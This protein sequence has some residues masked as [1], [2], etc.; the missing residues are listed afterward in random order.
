MYLSSLRIAIAG[1]AFCVSIL[2]AVASAEIDVPRERAARMVAEA[3]LA[4]PESGHL[5]FALSS[6]WLN[7]R[8]DEGNDRL[9]QWFQTG[10]RSEQPLETLLERA[11]EYPDELAR[12]LGGVKWSARTWLRIYYLF[13][14]R[15]LFFPGRLASDVEEKL[16]AL[17]W[18][19]GRDQSTLE[20]AD[21][22]YIWAIQGSENHDMM[23]LSNAFLAL[24]AVRDH[25]RYR[26]RELRDGGT[27]REHAAAWVDYYR[28]YARERA[29]YGLFV[30]ISSPIYGKHFLGELFNMH[31]F[32][33]DPVLRRSI[34]M[35]L[36]VTWADWAVDQLGGVRGGGK[37]RAYFG[38]YAER[39]TSDSW[40]TMSNFL[41]E[42]PTE[43]QL[44]W[45][46]RHGQVEFSIATSSYRLPEVVA[47]IALDEKGRGEFEYI[48]RRPAR[49][50][51]PEEMRDR[52][53]LREGTWYHLD[54]MDSRLVRYSYCTPAYVLGSLWLDPSLGTEFR[55]APDL[56]FS[57]D[58]NYAAISS[59]SQWQG[60][61]FPTDPNARV[62]PQCEGGESQERVNYA[63]HVA[64]QHK[65][66]L[67]V[68]K[69]RRAKSAGAMRV[70]FAPGMKER[71]VEREGW[72]YLEEGDAFLAVGIASHDVGAAASVFHWKGDRWLYLDDEFSP[73][74]FVAG[75]TGS[76]GDLEAFIASVQE[77]RYGFS[78]NEFSYSFTGPEGEGTRLS[79]F[80]GKVQGVPWINGAPIDFAPAKV[81]DSPFLAADFGSP[82]V[83]IRK[84]DRELV[85]DF[86]AVD[87]AVGGDDL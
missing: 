85:H 27:A 77:H 34:G 49:M 48:S 70:Y 25:P 71:L 3:T 35:L 83:T 63:Q 17:C 64:V 56:D 54:P 26:E 72:L 37:T 51:R 65:N 44:Q 20:R 55:L 57:A 73:V 42:R 10:H 59:Q 6:L 28:L 45:A 78:G 43:G 15:S 9:R 38:H 74:I 32:G 12:A 40:Y 30:E 84:G 22:K 76:H 5:Q 86:T 53:P 62:F 75:T 31:D 8:V 7:E 29:A 61:V 14:D 79:L 18:A 23:D 1:L 2:Q 52:P 69:H 16:E 19:Y 67:L 47:D 46:A 50:F 41:F 81:Y 68:Q 21:P 11:E 58:E 82:V 13:S 4:Y 60:V 33:E 39:G 80:V 87:E 24:Q 66:V 36:D